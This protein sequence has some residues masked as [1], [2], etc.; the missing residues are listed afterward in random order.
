MVFGEELGGGSYKL[1]G[2]YADAKSFAFV[3]L[4][5]QVIMVAAALSLV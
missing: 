3:K 4:S 2:G 1:S 5:R